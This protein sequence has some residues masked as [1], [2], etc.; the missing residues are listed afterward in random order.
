MAPQEENYLECDVD[1]HSYVYPA[2]KTFHSLI[3]EIPKI[4][5]DLGIVVE[6]REDDELPEQML[7]SARL[8][9]ILPDKAITL[10]ISDD[11]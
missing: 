9:C 3:P 5:V 11:E 8:S 10:D 2:R 6:A 4:V 1:I 7:A